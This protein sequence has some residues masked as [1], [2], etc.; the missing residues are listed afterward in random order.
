MQLTFPLFGLL[1]VMKKIIAVLLC[2]HL[3]IPVCEAQLYLAP[4][5]GY[6]VDINNNGRFKQISTALQLNLKKSNYYELIVLVQ[7]T[8]PV[9]AGFSDTAFSQNPSLALFT[10]AAKTIRPASFSIAVG[11]KVAILGANTNKIV[12]LLMFSGFTFQKME[13]AYQF[14]KANYTV[15]NPDK[16][17]YVDGLYLSW[18]IEYMRVINNGRLFFQLV[19]ATPPIRKKINYPASFNFLAPLS[20]NAGYAFQIKSK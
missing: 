20:F 18:G 15:L 3:A 6:Q 17:L 14:D 5:A 1:I 4:V 10:A 11:H 2:I 12:S 8:W 13:V 16:T 7:K 9:A 19:A